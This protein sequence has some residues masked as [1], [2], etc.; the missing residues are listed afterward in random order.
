M[1]WASKHRKEMKFKLSCVQDSGLICLTKVR[2]KMLMIVYYR[3][4]TCSLAVN[5][6]ATV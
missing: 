6:F 2:I 1:G 4:V 3:P 5:I